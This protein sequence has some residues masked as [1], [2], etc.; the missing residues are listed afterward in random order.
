VA[1][2]ISAKQTVAEL[3]ESYPQAAAAF[4]AWKTNCVGCHLARFCTLEDVARI[5]EMGTH[6]LVETLEGMAQSS[7]KE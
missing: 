1:E 6:D 7:K 2:S 3:L 5:Y 4:L